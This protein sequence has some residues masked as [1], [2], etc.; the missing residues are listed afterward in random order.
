M[1][2]PP[3]QITRQAPTDDPF[4]TEILAPEQQE[5]DI[6]I[7][8]PDK[9]QRPLVRTT[10]YVDGQIIDENKQE[11]FDQF[12][13]D[14]TGY[15]LS[16]QHSVIVEAVDSLGLSKTS[17]EIP[18][19]ITVIQPPRGVSAFF[20]KY[21]LYITIGAISLAALVLL[22]VLLT[23][24]VR[25]PTLRT[26]REEKRAFEDP[27]TQPLQVGAA[28]PTPLKEKKKRR[29]STNSTTKPTGREK[30]PKPPVDVS[31]YFA[32]FNADDTPASVSPIP[33]LDPEITF[34]SDPVQS[35]YVLDDPSISSSHARLKHNEQDEYFLYDAG[36]IA[37]TW[38]NY[39][40][41][42]REGHRLN[43]GD[44]VHFGQLIYRFYLSK[45]SVESKPKVEPEQTLE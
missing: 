30:L 45:P 5:I 39:E 2:N 44:M 22:A 12:T 35:K 25:I 36:S 1:V 19:T 10:L 40:P 23:G 24:R 17:M 6:I 3:L 33:L 32:R 18:V 15:T 21:R 27:L 38:V 29:A 20:A 16:G 9:H 41:I 11:P 26:R 14:L 28:A 43:H 34:G 4:N 7:E 8:F 37:G 13:W 31:A 42:T